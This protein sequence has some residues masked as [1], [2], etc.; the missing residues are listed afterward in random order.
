MLEGVAVCGAPNYSKQLKLPQGI[1]ARSRVYK[2]HGETAVTMKS[3]QPE[4]WPPGTW[5]EMGPN[6]SILVFSP[7]DLTERIVEPNS[8][9]E[10][11]KTY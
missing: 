3:G 4:T 8:T 11:L 7:E 6:T 1:V 9:G 10:E 5:I 2:R